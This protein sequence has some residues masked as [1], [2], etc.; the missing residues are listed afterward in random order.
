MAACAAGEKVMNAIDAEA[1]RWIERADRED[2]CA[3]DQAHLDAWM[4]AS[5]AHAVSYLRLY[6]AWLRADRLAALRSAN[7]ETES[8]PARSWMLL[9]RVAAVFCIVAI[10]GFAAAN[11]LHLPKD[12]LFK[13]P[14]GGR[15]TVRLSDGSL[16]ELNT[17]TQLRIRAS[18]EKRLVM[19][20]K[21]EAYFQV[22]H[23]ARRPFVVEAKDG[24]VVDL[25]T[26]FTVRDGA[27]HLEVAVVEGRARFVSAASRSKAAV[28]TP[29]DV[30]VATAD[31]MSVTKRSAQELAN[32]LGWRRGVLVFDHTTLADA[33]AELN[34]YNREKIVI[35]DPD[36]RRRIIGA[37]IPLNGVEAFTRVAE[38]I[39][40]VHVEKSGGEIII[41]R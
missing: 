14:V 4:A 16:I 40:G 6:D 9:M 34:R 23:D 22:H 37:T 27:D 17:S 38:K 41:S 20:D 28:L 31:S 13:T 18:A 1:A 30:V 3:A 7:A 19:L 15:E 11:Y 5:P 26:K 2:W 10:A 8:T 12:Q 36:V 29:G 21:G 32:A 35:A 25:G 39:F 33:A 24:R